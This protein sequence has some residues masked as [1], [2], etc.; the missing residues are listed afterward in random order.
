MTSQETLSADEKRLAE[1]GYKQALS[2][3]WSG[4]SNWTLGNKYKWINVIAVVWVA[5]CVIIFS[6]PFTTAAVP[7]SKHFS[8][9]AFNYAPLVT[10]VV[11]AGVTIWYLTSARRTFKGPIRT[12]DDLEL[13]AGPAAAA[14][15]VAPAS[16]TGT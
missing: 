13:D 6:L 9:S 2:R 10:I 16:P 12:I 1:L 5:L 4:F 8:W 7:F 14:Q 15:G 3:G 11:M